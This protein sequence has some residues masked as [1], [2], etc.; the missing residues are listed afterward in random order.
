MFTIRYVQTMLNR[1]LIIYVQTR[2]VVW[3]IFLQNICYASLSVGL[4]PLLII[5]F[6]AFIVHV[7]LP[8]DFTD[9][10]LVPIVKE[11]TGDIF[12]KGNYIPI[13]L[14]SV[15]SKVFEMSLLVKLEK[16]LYDYQFGFKPNHST[17]QCIIP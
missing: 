4:H 15:V 3:I 6:N 14:A 2:L 12:D 10:V 5:C 16:Y 1:Q 8:S 17:D 9:T 11:N 13:A 7:F